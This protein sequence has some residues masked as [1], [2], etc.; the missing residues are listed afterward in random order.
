LV[1]FENICAGLNN[2]SIRAKVMGIFGILTALFMAFGVFAL[3]RLA[4]INAGIIEVNTNWLPSVKVTSELKYQIA[5]H[6]TLVARHILSTEDA[7]IKKTDSDIETLL[8]DMKS[9]MASTSR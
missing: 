7:D 8:R 1:G 6:R 9:S 2:V 3:D 4:T 5:R